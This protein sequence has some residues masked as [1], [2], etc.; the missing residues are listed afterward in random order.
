MPKTI[1]RR[2]VLWGVGHTH[3]H[4]VRSW[5]DRPIAGAR[6]TCVSDFPRATYSGML[7]GVLAG[8]HDR[9]AMEI[10]LVDLCARAGAELI[11]GTVTGLDRSGRSLTV[12]GR[13]PLRYDALS[14]GI[15]SEPDRR[16]VDF[17]SAVVAIKP[18]QTFLDRLDDR[19]RQVGPARPLRVAIVGGGAGGSEVAFCLPGRVRAVLGDLPIEITLIDA[20]DRPGGLLPS[21]GR[22][23]RRV[24]EARGVRLETGRRVVRVDGE[25][26][27]LDDGGRIPA[28]LVLWAT[29]A[30][31]REPL[32]G[33][34][35]PIDDRGFLLTRPTLQ[36]LLDDRIFAVGDCGT[37]ATAPG[38]ARAG[39][40]AVREGPIL[41]ANLE[42]RLGGR[43]L[44]EYR[45]RREMLKLLNTGDGRAIGEFA[46]FSFEGRWA[47]L[48]E[49]S[50]RRFV[51]RYRRDPLATG[52]SNRRW[53]R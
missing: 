17:E 21:T 1:P 31:G 49:R 19:L 26:V 14:I 23:V 36:T 34:G 41:R 15:G 47:W 10:D 18:M 16:G 52:G 51:A 28:G 7:P 27:G 46:G 29:A 6:L 9:A 20:H 39:V 40:H 12:A 24:L 35:L 33:L 22:R 45:P 53:G 25:G 3:L 32:A 13:P 43:S 5:I 44:A 50:D 37:I 42:A 48:W 11:L 38:M 4:V 30:R 8:S 2:V